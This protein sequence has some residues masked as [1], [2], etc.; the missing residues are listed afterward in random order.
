MKN[1]VFFRENFFLAFWIV[2]YGYSIF[3][4]VILQTVV[5]PL[6][7]SLHSG[8]GLLT[9]DARVFHDFA[10]GWA[11]QIQREGWAAWSLFGKTA[12]SG[13]V[14]LLAAFYAIF[15]PNPLSFIFLSS[16]FHALGGVLLYALYCRFANSELKVAGIASAVVFLAFPS[17]LVWYAQNHKDTFL[18]VGY[19]LTLL[20]FLDIWR[21]TCFKGLIK[22]VLALLAGLLIVAW[23]RPLMLQIYFLSFAAPTLLIVVF[24]L[25]RASQKPLKSIS[26]MLF[27]LSVV[28]LM[29]KLLFVSSPYTD[30]TRFDRA[31]VISG[32]E[33]V[34]VSTP[35][36]PAA[37]DSRL[38][39]I[40][41]LR[42]H[43]LQSGI[44]SGARSIVD[45]D[46]APTNAVELMLYLPRAALVGVFGPFPSFWAETVSAPRVVAA[47]ETFVFYLL[48]PG[49]LFL[50]WRHSSPAIWLALIS[51]VAVITIQSYVSPNLGTLHRIRYGQWMILAAMGFAGYAYFFARRFQSGKQSHGQSSLKLGAV[52]TGMATLGVLALLVRDL[53]LVNRLG[54]SQQ[55]DFYYLALLVP[56]LLVNALCVP[57]AD[58]FTSEFVKRNTLEARQRLLNHL[59][60]FTT[61]VLFSL[62]VATV[63]GWWLFSENVK[64]IDLIAIFFASSLLALSA[65]TLTGNSLLNASGAALK[66]SLFQ[67]L[68]PAAVLFALAINHT[69]QHQVR[70]TLGAMVLGQLLNIAAIVWHL[71]ALGYKFQ[72]GN[73]S[74]LSLEKRLIKNSI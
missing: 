22:G 55:L 25:V 34:W 29:A 46:R 64:G 31:I 18:I 69:S 51:A 66:S 15:G 38:E 16:A 21:T 20:G 40:S 8:N 67:L 7:P 9:G 32:Q 6:I 37:I 23:M 45:S 43:F 19:L 36:L 26:R 70:I 54:F 12:T 13:N 71:H 30:L 5:L 62:A 28:G 41:K 10:V 14:S 59:I 35:G 61:A 27:A 24:H 56:M 17:A 63:L 11:A 44:E 50:L 3:C 65:L 52:V 48:M 2:A 39:T 73:V 58:P 74:Q 1:K 57:L 33:W 53:I 72:R 60:L 49:L 47:A 4:A 68:V 42:A